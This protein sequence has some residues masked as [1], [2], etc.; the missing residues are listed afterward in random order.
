M[1]ICLECE[2][3]GDKQA[4]DRPK[5]MVIKNP[6]QPEECKKD[7]HAAYS[8][9]HIHHLTLLFSIMTRFYVTYK[10]DDSFILSH[11]WKGGGH[12]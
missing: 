7:E 6:E 5:R 2:E 9:P 1:L 11:K 8:A 10:E 4:A 3:Y 12:N